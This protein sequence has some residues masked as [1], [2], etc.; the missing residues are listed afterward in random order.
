MAENKLPTKSLHPYD[1]YLDLCSKYNRFSKYFGID[2]YHDDFKVTWKLIGGCIITC[3]SLINFIYLGL[4]SFK[5]D[6]EE[7]FRSIC[8][9]GCLSQV[10]IAF[11]ITTPVT[12]TN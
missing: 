12:C 9:I 2:I 3:I 7:F 5:S 4:T 1:T 6:K 11:I 10:L 8:F